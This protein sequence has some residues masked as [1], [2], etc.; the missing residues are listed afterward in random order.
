MYG[1]CTCTISVRGEDTLTNIAEVTYAT[2][3]EYNEYLESLPEITYQSGDLK[4]YQR[5][6][7]VQQILDNFQGGRVLE[8]GADKCE[9]ADY[10]QKKG[11]EVW[12][13]DPYSGVGGGTGK[14]KEIK[15]KFRKINVIRGV[16]HEDDSLPVDY[17]D[18]IYS[19]SVLEHIPFIDIAPTVEKVFKFLRAGGL[20]IHAIDFTIEG[21]I[22]Q[23]YD[24]MNEILRCHGIDEG[25]ETIGKQALLDVG[26][27]YLSPIGHYRWRKFLGKSYEEYPYRKV[28]SLGLVRSAKKE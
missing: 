6:W 22:L 3:R 1:Y 12:V 14:Y 4:N 21:E 10:L 15:R 11:Y 20:S 8:I 24:L 2:V 17:F 23:N 9:L 25:A 7:V 27:Y 18:A 26:T 28:T 16:L 5:P 19:C 13:I